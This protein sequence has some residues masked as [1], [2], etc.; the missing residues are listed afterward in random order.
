LT[1]SKHKG[2]AVK[3]IA[4]VLFAATALLSSSLH[5][6]TQGAN[7]VNPNDPAV[8]TATTEAGQAAQRWLALLDADKFDTSW[9]ALAPV[10]K[11][12]IGKSDYQ[13]SMLAVREQYG[14][15]KTRRPS[16]VTFTHT[17][18]GAPDGDYVVLQYET[19]FAKGAHAAETVIPM[20]TTDGW[21]VSGYFVR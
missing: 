15:V 12:H 18:P 20:R 19:D 17:L 9:A 7:A 3:S 6:Q 4:A 16:K 5:A 11:E 1:V 14:G 21:R 8:K 2:A 10:A 13:A